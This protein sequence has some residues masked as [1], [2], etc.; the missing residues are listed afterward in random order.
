MKKY[1]FC[2]AFFLSTFLIVFM[3]LHC[4][5]YHEKNDYM[6]IESIQYSRH[7]VSAVSKQFTSPDDIKRIEKRIR[8]VNFYRTK[9]TRLHESPTSSIRIRYKD[10]KQKH[11]DIAGGLVL[12]SIKNSS[13]EFEMDK[14][15]FYSVSLFDIWLLEK[16]I[17]G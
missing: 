6:E 14:S 7:A 2:I 11:I 16:Y 4:V 8:H 10:G 17:F 15:K 5:S 9:E 3:V 12:I 13:G 1:I